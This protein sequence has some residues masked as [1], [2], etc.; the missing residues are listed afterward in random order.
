M[1]GDVIEKTEVVE[2]APIEIQINE[3]FIGRLE[4]AAS[5]YQD[6]YLPLCVKLTSTGDWV[7][8]G[9]GKFYLQCSGAEKLCNP[10]GI[11][12]DRPV[13]T[14]HEREDDGGHY[15]EYEV[16]GVVNCRSLGRWG[17]FTGNCS[18]RDQFFN[19]RGRFD[20]GD[21][22]KAA[23]SNWLVN[24]VTRLAGIRNPSPDLLRRAGLDPDAIGN[25]DYGNKSQEQ[26]KDVISE[27]Q[28]K[29]LYAISKQANVADD[30]VK[31]HLKE[32]YGLDSSKEIKR[33]DYEAICT[34]VQNGG[35][36]REPGQDG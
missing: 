26:G 27:A 33:K 13:V 3:E 9:K 18:S 36:D 30:T 25:I 24:A 21:I 4:K 20:E 23:F 15:Y 10:L 12:W 14:K 22:R 28:G 32:K 8:H 31:A 29:R 7:S 11:N 6:R 35:A 16:E 1:N 34:W 5:L 19:A 2:D 17:W